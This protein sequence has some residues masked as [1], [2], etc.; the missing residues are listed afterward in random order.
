MTRNRKAQRHTAAACRILIALLVAPAGEA[1][2]PKSPRKVG[3]AVTRE[4]HRL[5]ALSRQAVLAAQQ[6]DPAMWGIAEQ[7]N[8]IAGSGTVIEQSAPRSGFNVTNSVASLDVIVCPYPTPQT[9]LQMTEGAALVGIFPYGVAEPIAAAAKARR[10]DVYDLSRARH[11][12]PDAE[13][14]DVLAEYNYASAAATTRHLLTTS[15]IPLTSA[16]KA[17]IL[18]KG[19]HA[20]GA[21]EVL[22][23]LGVGTHAFAPLAVSDATGA[24]TR[25]LMT[26]ALGESSPDFA[27]AEAVGGRE[28]IINALPHGGDYL[29]GRKAQDDLLSSAVLIL[30]LSGSAFGHDQRLTGDASQPLRRLGDAH[31]GRIADPGHLPLAGETLSAAL[32]RDLLRP[33]ITLA[34]Q[35][36][37]L[38]EILVWED[39]VTILGMGQLIGDGEPIL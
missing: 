35:G 20:A 1:A 29:F 32:G 17:A 34:G 12:T 18:G 5:I 6:S 9:V 28:I 30:D 24:K 25:W 2:R 31:I 10:L 23:E 13:H 7:I 38:I 26:T 3:F 27:L 39:L 19:S 8:F 16:P 33:D 36:R 14:A 22:T 11:R 21:F 37:S 4:P 15:E